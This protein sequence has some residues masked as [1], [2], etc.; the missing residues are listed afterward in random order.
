[1][2]RAIIGLLLL[3]AIVFQS[4][5]H[6]RAPGPPSQPLDG[7]GGLRYSHAHMTK[8]R[9]G[10]GAQEYWVYEPDAPKPRT[11]PLI[12]FFHGWGGTNPAAYGAWLDHLVKRG[13]IVV[14]PRYQADLSTSLE[15]F[16]PT[17]I[18]VVKDAIKRLQT[19]PGH[20]RPEIERFA[21]VGHSV[22]GLLTANLAAL[23]QKSGL[24]RVRALMSV[25]PGRTWNPIRRANV[26][27]ADLKQIPGQTLLLAVA[28]DSDN[29]A[30]ATDAKRIYY[31]STQVPAANKDFVMLVSDQ[32]GQPNLKADHF[33]PVSPD[34][35]YDNGERPRENAGDTQRGGILRERVRE[36]IQGRQQERIGAKESKTGNGQLPSLLQAEPSALVNAL[37]YYGLWKLFDALCDAAFYSRN[38]EYALGN[39][40]RQ[41][42]MGTWSDGV[43]VKE[44]IVTN[45]P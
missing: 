21:V 29:L 32:H 15:D 22:G 7:P 42:F 34:K 5:S 31:E 8:T 2:W 11:A 37:D 24:P 33:A 43:P 1:M 25:E 9:Y 38:R 3:I 23:A 13:N 30:R 20:V 16:T 19:E 17:V 6:S 18:E 4:L 40:A 41:R 27:L 28:G 10:Q 45:K 12:V 36:R 26:P 35:A 44:L 39:T 14:Y